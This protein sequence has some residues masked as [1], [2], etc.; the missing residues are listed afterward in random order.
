M[1]IILNLGDRLGCWSAFQRLQV[2]PWPYVSMTAAMGMC[3]PA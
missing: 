2:S 1:R 3:F